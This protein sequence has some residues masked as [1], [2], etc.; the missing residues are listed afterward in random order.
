MNPYTGGIFSRFSVSR[1]DCAISK[2]VIPGGIA[3]CTGRSSNVTA[4]GWPHPRPAQSTSDPASTILFS[5]FISN[6]SASI[7]DRRTSYCWGSENFLLRA[8]NQRVDSRL[9]D[10]LAV[11]ADQRGIDHEHIR[12]HAQCE[13]RYACEVEHMDIFDALRLGDIMGIRNNGH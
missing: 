4:I 3:P 8:S 12:D 9:N 13:C 11:A 6:S 7:G 1:I 10:A 2:R 5:E